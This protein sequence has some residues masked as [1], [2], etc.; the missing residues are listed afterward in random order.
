MKVLLRLLLHVTALALLP[1]FLGAQDIHF[2]QFAY[3]PLHLNP[4][5]AGAFR[6]DMRFSAQYRSQWKSVPVPYLT[7]SAAYDQKLLARLLPDGVLGVGGVLHF[8]KA[9]DADLRQTQ[10]GLNASYT[11][12][13]SDYWFLGAGFQVL[14]NQKAVSPQQLTFAEQWTGDLFD[15]NAPVTENFD[16][17][18]ISLF[19]AGTGINLHF[20]LDDNRTKLDLGAAAYHLNEPQSSFLGAEQVPFPRKVNGYALVNALVHPNADVVFQALYSA[21]GPYSELVTILGGRY[22]LSAAPGQELAF[23]ATLGMRWDDA[24]IPGIEVQYLAWRVGVSYDINLSDFEVATFKRGGPEVS[25]Q[26]IFTRVQP[27][28]TFKACPIF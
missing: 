17:T 6:G 27:P 7:F 19:S 12:Q 11:Q 9:G 15:P 25:V 10:L 24:L 4:A 23:G 14:L 18:S 16:N 28:D 22:Y 26:Y 2:S 3:N 21:Q 1:P 8:D 5:L 13:L 20:Q